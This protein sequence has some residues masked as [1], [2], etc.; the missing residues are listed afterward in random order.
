MAGG[1]VNIANPD[2]S[3][4]SSLSI[5]KAKVT[6]FIRFTI[7]LTQ[8]EGR[9]IAKMID[10]R[11]RSVHRW[12]FPFFSLI[13]Q[14]V[15]AIV[16]NTVDTIRDQT[17][18]RYRSIVLYGSYLTTR[19]EFFRLNGI[20]L[21]RTMADETRRIGRDCG[22]PRHACFHRKTTL[23]IISSDNRHLQRRH[24]NLPCFLIS[25]QSR[26]LFAK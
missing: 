18:D 20:T 5:T 21:S 12:P 15:T 17:S 25:P 26:L 8:F 6:L 11:R 1:Y 13:E 19:S 24:D 3:I 23:A 4:A 7:P 2:A 14:N 16:H 10:R 9:S 22:R